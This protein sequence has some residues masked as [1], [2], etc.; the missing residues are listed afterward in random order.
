[1]AW[2]QKI[3]SVAGSRLRTYGRW[4]GGIGCRVSFFMSVAILLVAVLVG[5]FFYATGKNAVDLEIRGRA[6]Y[7]AGHI[8]ELTA[9]DIITRDAYEVY[10]KI[11]PA[12]LSRDP[13]P[14]QRNII[15]ISVYDRRGDLIVGRAGQSVITP[16]SAKN[17]TQLPSG[18]PPLWEHLDD[19]A[20]KSPD[21]TFHLLSDGTYDLTY[22]VVITGDAV[23][24]IRIGLSGRL[25]SEE[26][27][28]FARRGIVA[29]IGVFMLGLIFSQIIAVSITRPLS[30]LSQAVEELGRQN[31][32]T[33]L[34]V[35]GRDEIATLARSFNQMAVAL[36]QREASLSQGNRDLFILHAAGLDLME[37]LD[38]DA[39]LRK[40]AGRAEDLVR[41]DTV[42]LSVVDPREKALKYLAVFG[43]KAGQLKGLDQ[44]L[45]A[46]GVYNWIVSY[47]SPLLILEAHTDFRLNREQAEQIG[48]RCLMSVP[49]WSSNSMIGLLTAFNKKGGTCFDRHDLRLFTVFSNMVGSALQNA[50]LFEDLKKSMTEV[51]LAQEQLVRS[52]KMAAIGELAANVAHEINNPLTSVLGY[53]SHLMK[54]LDL[55]EQPKRLLSII[56][57]ETLRVRKIIRNLLDFARQRPTRMQPSDLLQPLKETVALVQ[58][59]AEA[60]SIRIHEE[61]DGVPVIVNMNPNEIKQVFINIVNNAI[62]AMPQ[63]GELRIRLKSRAPK[64]TIVEFADTGTGI[65][66]EHIGKIF[67]P[68]FSTKT[69]GG[70]TGLGLSISYRI[71]Q[72]HGGRIEVE[73]EPGKGSLF[74]VVLPVYPEEH[75]VTANGG[76]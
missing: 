38:M 69:E 43:S 42:A 35:S 70:G 1:M 73:S 31:W 72:N 28:I 47:G 21:P 17:P 36:R 41:A 39:L 37:S 10:R 63:G 34:P 48:I 40:I 74:R 27:A 53:T 68:F 25:H 16:D 45:E 64:E 26:F 71:V 8:A 19:K 23:G 22:P 55:P 33:P 2:I 11:I 58:G 30:Q 62:Q 3:I 7:I 24:F 54:T 15:Y 6:L 51:R 49:L 57:Q 59:V 60:S 14:T 18:T 12:F 66:A 4:F 65:P 9:D 13:S 67:E 61:Y 5:A 56:E 75:L 44:A 46:G 20:L 32:K 50:R 76:I 29:F 52:T